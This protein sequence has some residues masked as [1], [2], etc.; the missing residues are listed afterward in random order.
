MSKFKQLI[1]EYR[2]NYLTENK[3]RTFQTYS[4]WCSAVKKL[5]PDVEIK[6]DKDIA[7]A[8]VKGKFDAEWDG[9]K[10]TIEP[11]GKPIEEE[12]QSNDEEE[13][14][15]PQEEMKKKKLKNLD[16]QIADEE[17]KDKEEHLRTLKTN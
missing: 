15:T 7:S 10:G 4:S 6:G 13:K 1:K 11:T 8:F 16:N 9:E 17:I 5:S 12:V 14:P 3:V 2:D